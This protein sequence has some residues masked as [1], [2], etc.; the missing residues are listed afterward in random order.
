MIAGKNKELYY[1]ESIDKQLNIEVIGTKHVIDNTTRE[2]DTFTLTETLN[3][4]TELKF[5]SCMPNQISFTG[6]EVP[7]ATKGM[8]LRPVEILEGNE[9]D[10]FVYGTYTVQSDTPTADRTKRQ[11]VAYDAM[12]DIINSNV[13]SWYDGLSFP[14]TLKAF[15]DSFFAHLG[16]EQKETNL[17]NDSMIVNKTLVTTQSEDSSVT[18]ESTISGKTIIEAICEINGAFGNIGRDGK[19]EY[20]ILPSIVSA[21]Y[22]AE[23]LYPRDDL[24]PSDANTESMTGHYI[25]FDYESFQSKAIT[26]LE[27]RADDSTAGAV[28]GN[29][30]NTYV[31]SG[32]FLISDKTGAELEQIANN[33][34]PIMKQA[35]YTPIKSC[36]CVGNPCLELGDPIRFN[37]SQEIVET[38]ILQRT[39]TGVQSK[40][41]SIVSQGV[42]NHSKNTNSMRE[43]LA[44]VQNRTSTLERN[45]DH[46]LAQFN[47][48]DENTSSQLEMTASQIQAEVTARLNSEAEMSTR[49]SQSAHSIVLTASGGDQSVGLTIQ[50]YEENGNV[51]DTSSGN[52]NITVTGF[53]S[54]FDLANAGSTSINGANVNTGT[55]TGVTFISNNGAEQVEI[56][57]GNISFYYNW[58]KLGRLRTGSFTNASSKLGIMLESDPSYVLGVGS[59]SE[60]YFLIDPASSKVQFYAG[61]VFSESCGFNGYCSFDGTARFFNTVDFS[62][63]PTY[64]DSALALKSEIPSLSGYIKSV[65]SPSWDTITSNNWVVTSFSLSKSGSSISVSGNHIKKSL[66]DQ[67][68]KEHLGKLDERYAE[69]YKMLNPIIFK[70]HDD[71]PTIKG[72]HFGLYANE[73]ADALD[74]ANIDRSGLR[75]VWQ[76]EVDSEAHEDRYINDRTW[77]LD[78]DELHALHIYMIQSQQKEIE[79]LKSENFSLKGE[80]DILKKRL[81]QMEEILN[82]INSK[83]S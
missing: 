24:F 18:A 17:V 7:I 40:R 71:I 15:R 78:Y 45:A 66:S 4:G 47:D 67:R 14:M 11:I 27:I 26:Q 50:L 28:V 81:N 39:L 37:T 56:E 77:N 52:A 58:T 29:A 2:Q 30:G 33:L 65:G 35:A 8:K 12:Y 38:Y 23:D 83:I 61:A 57:N 32:N 62:K 13:K 64:G 70:F 48:L 20:V 36:T 73:V 75:L 80:V 25:T 76:S 10:P 69:F 55:I 22:P 6:R 16:I 49:I 42:E 44:N 1:T 46:L 3:D 59:G 19:F 41:D 79:Q 53:V 21:L 72:K 43:T 68:L 5:G 9:D 54:F 31:I 60:Y 63:R 51:I 34:L 74:K 82:V